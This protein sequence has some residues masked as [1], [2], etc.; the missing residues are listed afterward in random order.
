MAD[1]TRSKPQ[2]AAVGVILAAGM[3]TRMKSKLPKVLHPL[4][5][6]PMIGYAVRALEQAGVSKVLAVLGYGADQ[7][8]KAMEGRIQPVYQKE[9]L[10]TGHALM[11]ALP[12][13]LKQEGG[14]CLVINGDMPLLTAGTLA[15]LRDERA[16]T[17]AQAAV[18]TAVVGEPKGYG[19]I[20]RE[21]GSVAAIVEE[22]D[23]NDTQRQIKEINAG[24]YC[25]D[26]GWL[27]KALR[28]LSPANAQGE[29]YLPDAIA[30]LVGQ[31]QV[32][33]ALR[34]PD[35]EEIQ[36]IN[37]RVQLAHAQDDLRHRILEGH[38]LE[39]VTFE[40]PTATIV[41]PLVEIGR[42]TVVETGCQLLGKTVIGEGCVIGPRSRII[43]SSI[44]DGTVAN[45]A[46]ITECKVGRDCD[47][48]PY[49]YM[50]PGCVLADNVKAGAFVEMKLAIIAAGAKVPHLSYM[51]DCTVG[52]KAN[53]GAGTI[54]CNYDGVVKSQTTIGAGAFIGSNSNLVA[55]V[56]VG[57]GAYTAAGST[58]IQD[59]PANSLGIARG[60]QSNII[61]WRL[62]AGK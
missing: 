37:D 36:G 33:A 41:G 11:M 45:Q 56:T 46:Q 22:K 21:E 19:R 53:I 5:G 24:A 44:G 54:T 49:T 17:G 26:I 35:P 31:G 32:V 9:Q 60:K 7:V 4:L 15:A 50:R 27:A 40:E 10:G 42:D 51:G 30:W 47:I 1:N 8:E 29:Y 61:D 12:E 28:E 55:P 52:E 14:D 57:D 48:G 62:R 13:L 3:G 20:I 58:I 34:T 16:K 23:A 25:F 18:L 43:D 2:S 6:E 59:V 39:G 38:M